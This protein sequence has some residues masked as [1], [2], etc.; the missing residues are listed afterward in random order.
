M[1][2]T[3]LLV[4]LVTPVMVGPL[5]G[6]VAA[7]APASPATAAAPT[8][9]PATAA[10]ATAHPA[11]A[12]D[13]PLLVDV[14]A[15]RHRGFDRVVLE[16]RGGLPE[17]GG[18]RYVDRLIADGSGRRIRIAGQA[19]LRLDLQR[20]RAHTDQGVATAPRRRAFALPNVMTAVRAGD[21]EGV[22]SYGLG[23]ARRGAFT[24]TRLRAPDRVVVDV[25]ADFATVSRKVW[26][27]DH[28]R[29]VANREPFFTPVARPVPPGTPATGLMDRLFAGP[30]PEEHAAGLRLLRSGASGYADLAVAG[31]VARVRMRGRCHGGG[32]TVTLAGEVLPTL[33]QLPTVDWVKLLDP[34]G[35]TLT[36][37]GP[38]D[39]TPACLEP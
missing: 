33:R 2:I 18:A 23:L 24:I 7:V 28:D 34:A 25:R 39:S 5:A 22:V 32:S 16:F 13:A 12:G 19:I 15:A 38:V 8:A 29:Y 10:P 4:L 14:R 35:T 27:F 6:P 37:A 31:G 26:F 36:P 11:A 1:R 9:A 30:L 21:F 20:A 3:R 17:V